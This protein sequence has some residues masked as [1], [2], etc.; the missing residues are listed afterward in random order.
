LLRLGQPT[1]FPVTVEYA[2]FSSMTTTT[3]WLRG[4]CPPIGSG[5]VVKGEVD[6]E[7]LLHPAI[8]PAKK[9]RIQAKLNLFPK[10]SL[11]EAMCLVNFQTKMPDLSDMLGSD[12]G[13]VTQRSR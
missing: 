4:T 10:R 11:R 13:F 2:W 3:C 9:S 6:P 8:K 5:L 7:P 12:D 1:A